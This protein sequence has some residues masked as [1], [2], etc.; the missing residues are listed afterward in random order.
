MP[1]R[2]IFIWILVSVGATLVMAGVYK[3]NAYSSGF[4]S[5][6][7]GMTEEQV[8]KALGTADARRKAC[9]DTPTWQGATISG[10]ECSFELQYDA[11]LF[12]KFWTIG[13]GEDGSVISKYEYVSP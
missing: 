1:R 2:S 3:N 11:F 6:V 5:V 7:R 12:P 13:F 10:D 8:V 4:A 9:R